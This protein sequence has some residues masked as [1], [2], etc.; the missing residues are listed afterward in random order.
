MSERKSRAIRIVSVVSATIIALACGTNY[1]YSAWG[2]QFAERMQLSST[3]QNL[4]VSH[5]SARCGSIIDDLFQGTFAN[6]GMYSGGIPV[7]LLV[8]YKGP[9]PAVI[10]GGALLVLGYFGNHR[11]FEDGPGSIALP[12]MCLFAYMTGIGGAAAFASA[13]KTFGKSEAVQVRGPSDKEPD[14]TSSLVS[15]S[16]SS[17]PGDVPYRPDRSQ[18][19][20]END[21]HYVD[22]RG[23]AVLKQIEFYQ[24]WLLLG[25]LTGVGLMTINNIGNDASLLVKIIDQS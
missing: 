1:A 9:K 19:A 11:A 5:F 18:P 24:L 16:T 20:P 10:M 13:I 7:G 25:I 12:W 4:I 6:L 14:E 8:D 23:L 15:K 17:T 22:I 21:L 2:P 3:Q